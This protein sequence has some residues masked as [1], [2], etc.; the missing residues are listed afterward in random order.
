MMEMRGAPVGT[1]VVR[2]SRNSQ[3]DVGS[4]V[5]ASQ[6]GCRQQW[7][8]VRPARGGPSPRRHVEEPSFSDAAGIQPGRRIINQWVKRTGLFA[9]MPAS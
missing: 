3:P 5:G 4:T 8:R 2:M 9:T 7:R 1:I 6:P